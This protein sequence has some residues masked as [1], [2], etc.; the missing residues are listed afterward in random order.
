MCH[1]LRTIAAHRRRAGARPRTELSRA[2]AHAQRGAV[3]TGG[4]RRRLLQSRSRLR[5]TRSRRPQRRH[6]RRAPSRLDQAHCH[7]AGPLALSGRRPTPSRWRRDL[8]GRQRA[9]MGQ[10]DARPARGRRRARARAGEHARRRT[11]AH[12]STLSRGRAKPGL[13]WRCPGRGDGHRP[14][15]HGPRDPPRPPRG[16]GLSSRRRVRAAPPA[17]G[18]GARRHRLRRRPARLQALE[19]D[20]SRRPRRAG[21]ATQE[22]RGLESRG[23]ASRPGRGGGAGVRARAARRTGQARSAPPRRLCQGSP[24][25]STALRKR[26]RSEGILR[27]NRAAEPCGSPLAV[28]TPGF[29]SRNT[30]RRRSKP[31]ATISSTSAPSRPTPSTIPTMPG[32]WDRPYCAASWTRA[33]SSAA[34][35]RAP[36]SPRTRSGASAPRFA[37]IRKPPGSPAWRT[38][39]TCSVSARATSPPPARWPSPWRGSAPRSRARSASRAEC[40]RSPCS[41]A[42]CTARKRRRHDRPRPPLLP[43]RLRLRLLRLPWLLLRLLRLRPLRLRPLLLRLVLLRLFRL[44]PLRL[45]P[46]LLRPLLLRLLRL[47]LRLLRLRCHRLPWLLLRL[48]QL[49]LGCHRLPSLLLRLLRLRSLRLRLLLL[50]PLRL[51]LRLLLR[52]PLAWQ[53]LSPR[54]YPSRTCPPLRLH[55]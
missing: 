24:A 25:P 49:G 33:C 10:A 45:R 23:G 13:A 39:P 20:R 21:R 44:R 51:R 15:D 35:E 9:G 16:R 43:R 2:M 28:T 17:G 36:P 52:H 40:P 6:L 34:A 54:L 29:C 19:P 27:E 55:R 46:L 42:G 12:G 32:P 53:P 47:R 50:R 22:H 5:H 26:C 48:L 3:A 11:W 1:R 41:R 18:T 8:G 14:L 38:T 31:T 37:T 30:C 7:P 4:G